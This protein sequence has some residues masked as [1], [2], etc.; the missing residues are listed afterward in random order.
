MK[1]KKASENCDYVNFPRYSLPKEG[2][3]NQ[4]MLV[5]K[6]FFICK[7]QHKMVNGLSVYCYNILSNV[8]KICC[9]LSIN[10]CSPCYCDGNIN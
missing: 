3:F 9:S 10:T 1:M 6:N 8:G 4:L 2:Q 5:K 7:Y